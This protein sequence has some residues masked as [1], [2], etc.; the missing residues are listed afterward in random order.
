M[1]VPGGYFLNLAY[2]GEPGLKINRILFEIGSNRLVNTRISRFL[3]R[4]A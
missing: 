3:T 4:I 1:L 2:V